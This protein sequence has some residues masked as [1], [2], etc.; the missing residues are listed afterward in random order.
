[1]TSAYVDFFRPI[2]AAGVL[3]SDDR[4]V[5]GRQAEFG[6]AAISQA[7]GASARAGADGNGGPALDALKAK[8]LGFRG[9]DGK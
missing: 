5:H 6:R 4:R 9:R 8:L 2:H 3:R 7:L 1:M